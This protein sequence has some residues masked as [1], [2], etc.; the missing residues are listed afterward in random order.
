M[1]FQNSLRH[2]RGA[3]WGKL[4]DVNEKSGCDEKDD[5]VSEKVTLAKK[6]N[7]IK[8][9]LEIFHDLVIGKDKML[10]VD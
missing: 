9:T 3:Q 6:K 10:E 4:L 2:S 1:E 8:G 5:D 7:H